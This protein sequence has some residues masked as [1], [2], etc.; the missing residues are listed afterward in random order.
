MFF[1]NNFLLFSFNSIQRAISHENFQIQQSVER[2]R[3]LSEDIE[4]DRNKAFFD[5]KKL[6]EK[7]K[8]KSIGAEEEIELFRICKR[9]EESYG[10]K[11]QKEGMAYFWNLVVADFI[12]YRDNIPYSAKSCQRRVTTKMIQ[13]K[14]ELQ[15]E[16]IGSEKRCT[17]WTAAIDAWIKV[18][19]L[20]EI[21]EKEKKGLKR[22]S[23]SK[24]VMTDQEKVGNDKTPDYK[25][26][27]G[28]SAT[29]MSEAEITWE[30][31]NSPGNK[32][33]WYKNS[34]NWFPPI[35]NQQSLYEVSEVSTRAESHS[36]KVGEKAKEQEEINERLANIENW[37]EKV[38]KQNERIEK[39]LDKLLAL[40]KN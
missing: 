18:V 29:M 36:F 21:T 14:L 7:Q 23:L 38:Y 9:H 17:E 40:M 32:D 11:G 31:E 20:Y 33:G 2:H 13:R 28:N 27:R 4:M 5:R 22:K 19:E 15:M 34:A 25:R 10:R 6:D 3:V 1:I 8:G 39:R 16:E 35:Q 24:S 12:N 37:V 30:E 26:K